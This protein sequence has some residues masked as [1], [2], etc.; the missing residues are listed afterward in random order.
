MFVRR[1]HNKSGTCS[2]QVI[3]K[4]DGKYRVQ[5]SFGSSRDE[6]VLASLE[7]KAKQWANE[8]EFGEDLFTPDGAAD[9]DAMMAGIG[10]D[11]PRL[12]QGRQECQSAGGSGSVGRSRW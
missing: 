7:Q 3:A 10:Q 12:V 11:H 2:I 6:A 1:K 5:K 9:Y 8:H 4:I